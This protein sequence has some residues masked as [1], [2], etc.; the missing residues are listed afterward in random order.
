MI[1]KSPI[2]VWF[3]KIMIHMI[4]IKI[5]NKSFYTNKKLSDLV[6]HLYKNN[7]NNNCINNNTKLNLRELYIKGDIKINWNKNFDGFNN[8]KYSFDGNDL[9]EYKKEDK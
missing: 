6:I 8:Y 9:N 3:V 5:F 1:M 4:N 7:K 2:L